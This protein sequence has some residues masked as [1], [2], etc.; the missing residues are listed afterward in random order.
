M[1]EQVLLDG[2]RP[3]AV[4]EQ[5]EGQT[6]V[7]GADLRR[8]QADVLDQARPAALAQVTELLGVGGGAVTPVVPGVDHEPG[9][10]QR[11]GDVVV[12]PRVLAYAV[13]Q[14]DRAPRLARRVPP[15]GGDLRAVR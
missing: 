7:L 12:A 10:V 5:D 8:E 1:V 3:H 13:R 14:L 9:V 4:A 11:P 15:V 2:E 6:R